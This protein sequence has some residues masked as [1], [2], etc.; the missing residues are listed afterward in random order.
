MKKI[1]L[2]F[3]VI[4][5]SVIP[6]VAVVACDN[7]SADEVRQKWLEKAER[8]LQN[9]GGTSQ[10]SPFN[11]VMQSDLDF[12]LVDGSGQRQSEISA[13]STE[14]KSLQDPSV[15]N[16]AQYDATLN[17]LIKPFTDEYGNTII[18]LIVHRDYEPIRPTPDKD[19]V[20]YS[21]TGIYGNE[22]TG[23]KVTYTA[24]V[25]YQAQHQMLTN[26]VVK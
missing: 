4:A 18:S 6:V 10:T 22:K 7:D 19:T 2:S 24:S 17:D 14:I 11:S 8:W 1:L 3:G 9:W 25:S 12:T 20:T 15:G 16:F 13:F 26:P 23:E 5:S 21:V